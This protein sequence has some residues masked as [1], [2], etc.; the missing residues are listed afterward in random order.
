LKE[1]SMTLFR[2]EAI[3][4]QQVDHAQ[5]NVLVRS[6]AILWFFSVGAIL[7]S[8]GLVWLACNADYTQ[9]ER[10]YGRLISDKPASN[11]T[12]SQSGVVQTSLVQQGAQVLAGQALF[13][14]GKN[15]VLERPIGRVDTVSTPKISKEEWHII[16]PHDG[17]LSAIQVRTGQSIE[18]GQILA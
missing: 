11:L 15:P 14:V 5:G 18:I 8:I 13:K 6:P 4:F 17:A 12:A 2:P 10:A 1:T 16:A 3:E 7:F 9:K